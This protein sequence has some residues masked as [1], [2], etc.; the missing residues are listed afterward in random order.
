MKG[1]QTAIVAGV[2]WMASLA[3]FHLLG[4]FDNYENKPE[5][6]VRSEPVRPENETGLR[7]SDD[8]M[9]VKGNIKGIDIS[10]GKHNKNFLNEVWLKLEKC[11]TE[12][13]IGD[14][15]YSGLEVDGNINYFSYCTN[16]KRGFFHCTDDGHYQ[17]GTLTEDEAKK[18][19]L[20]GNVKLYKVHRICRERFGD[21]LKIPYVRERSLDDVLKDFEF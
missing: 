5:E 13:I 7:L 9:R 14:E 20:W 1:Y 3:G 4:A 8:G 10:Y 21:K 2:F 6:P 11:G 12:I 19:R 17:R 16:M 15:G 18:L